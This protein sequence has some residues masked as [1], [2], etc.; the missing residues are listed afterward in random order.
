MKTER[1]LFLTVHKKFRMRT[2]TCTEVKSMIKIMSPLYLLPYFFVQI[3]RHCCK[4][5]TITSVISGEF[6]VTLANRN[7]KIV[8]DNSKVR[9]NCKLLSVKR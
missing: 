2:A 9:Q 5:V 3:T 8:I 4:I 6:L 1:M 7:D